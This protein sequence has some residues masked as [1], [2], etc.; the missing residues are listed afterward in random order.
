MEILIADDDPVFLKYLESVVTNLGF[1]PIVCQNGQAVAEFIEEGKVPPIVL[2]D[3][4]MP[5]ISGIDLCERIRTS[6]ELSKTHVILITGMDSTKDVIEALRK[7]ANDYLTKPL[8][9]GELEVRLQ[10][11]R[12]IVDLHQTV[13]NHRRRLV[14]N[15][16]LAIL[17]EMSAGIVHEISNPLHLVVVKSRQILREVTQESFDGKK[18]QEYGEAIEKTILR[19]GKIIRGLQ[20][21][22]KGK[23]Q[24]PFEEASLKQIVEETLAFSGLSIEDKG[25]DLRLK[26]LEG[27]KLKCRDFQISQVL[28]NLINNSVQAIENL[29]D[30]WIELDSY[31]ESNHV[32]ISIT[33]SG[34][35]IPSSHRDKI[36]KP[37]FSTKSNKIGTGL[38]L[39]IAKKII[40]SHQ[41][42]L[43]IDHTCKNTKFIVRFPKTS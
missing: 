7:G 11:A 43:Q 30:R 10:V 35:G 22:T 2:L 37:F 9:E 5:D 41:G 33:D 8:V 36:L 27:T 24:D 39:T 34:E 29:K 15:A 14:E 3:W 4:V 21:F 6:P 25:V 42:E 17:G 38:G 23:E 20:S 40:D 1:K 32:C 12:K 31:E 16:R 13:E 26:N 18:I 28:V 19:M